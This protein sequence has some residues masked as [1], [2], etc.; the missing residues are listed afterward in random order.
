M[1]IL[2][3]GTIFIATILNCLFYEYRVLKFTKNKDIQTAWIQLQLNRKYK[4]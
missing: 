2:L 1:E 4:C 3:I